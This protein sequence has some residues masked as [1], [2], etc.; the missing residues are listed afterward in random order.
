MKGLAFATGTTVYLLLAYF[1][2]LQV[3]LQCGLGPDSSPTCN[4]R[5]DQELPFVFPILAVIY[6]VGSVWFWRRRSKDS[7]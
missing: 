3:L 1:I 6:I 5:V 2:W 4:A 7:K